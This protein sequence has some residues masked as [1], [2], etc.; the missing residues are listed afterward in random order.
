[1]A[2]LWEQ[3]VRAWPRL[4]ESMSGLDKVMTL[5]F[6]IDG[7]RVIAQC[8][9]GRIASTA[10]NIDKQSLANRR[11]FLCPDHLP[12][13]QAVITWRDQWLIAC[14]PAPIITPHFTI[15][16]TDHRPQ[17]IS[18]CMEAMLDLASDLE[19]RYTIMYNGPGAGASA[20]DHLHL[21]AC[22]ADRLPFEQELLQEWHQSH[23]TEGNGWI[24]W[25]RRDT[26]I[27][28]TTR[29]D[30]RPAVVVIGTDRSMLLNELR[31]VFDA[32][33]S[34]D[35]SEPEPRMNLF[36]RFVENQWVIWVHPRAAHRPSFYGDN[37]GRFLISPGALDM[38]GILVVP[39]PSDFERLTG[40]MIHRVFEEVSCSSQAMAALRNRVF[41]HPD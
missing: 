15:I 28:G 26:C 4:A 41:P 3:Q 38:A 37:E 32:M 36:V 33:A 10:A 31:R 2:A 30:K 34:I 39:R 25:R 29:A 21:Q 16:S 8:N 24:D 5:E 23:P 18:A 12:S 7:A 19:G 14:N 1:V 17:L 40:D 20:P 27:L 35:G 13:E 22:E 6:D 11:C 9:P